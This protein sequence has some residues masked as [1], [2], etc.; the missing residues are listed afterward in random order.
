MARAEFR[1]IIDG[2]DLTDEQHDHIA[3]AVQEAGV[4]AVSGVAAKGAML[5]I[6]VG[7]LGNE[8]E[9][10]GRILLA[11][12]MAAEALKQNV[13]SLLTQGR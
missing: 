2:L 5:G 3:R 1:F 8:L 6:D 7:R 4:K 9:W 12:D 10:I 11:N 13:G